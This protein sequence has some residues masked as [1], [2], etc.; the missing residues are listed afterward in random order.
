MTFNLKERLQRREACLGSWITLGHPAIAE[1][2]ADAGF[3]W[4]AIDLEHSVIGLPEAQTLIR[5]IDS[6]GVTPLVR[7]TANDPNQAKRLLD[8]G[9]RG[10]IVPMVNS[11]AQAQ[12]AVQAVRYPPAGARGV[13]L[14]RAQGYGA[15]FAEYLAETEP[16]LVVVAQ[17]EHVDAV[18]ALRD[19]LPV[20]GIDATII[21][22]YDLSGSVGKPGQFDDP[23]VLALLR[24]YEAVSRSVGT[25]MGFHVIDPDPS[26]VERKLDAGYTFVGY[27]VDFL[28]LGDACRQGMAQLKRHIDCHDRRQNER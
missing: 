22:P 16:G 18:R 24:E 15:R 5:V 21:G 9:A 28:F 26:G 13:G 4:L 25:P 8:A 23:E 12:A 3:D 20:P 17:I 10:V 7:L 11:A 14:A 27:S 19:I 1:I 2:M 6:V